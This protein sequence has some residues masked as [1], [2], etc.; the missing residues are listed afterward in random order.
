[1]LLLS[2]LVASF[3]SCGEDNPALIEEPVEDIAPI[4]SLSGDN[5]T[6]QQNITIEAG[7]VFTLDLTAKSG[8]YAMKSFSLKQSGEFVDIE[9]FTVNGQAA[10]YNP[11]LLSG[12]NK[13]SIAWNIEIRSHLEEGTKVYE[14]AIDD[15]EDLESK[16]TLMVTTEVSHTPPSFVIQEKV[17]FTAFPG[18]LVAIPIQVSTGSSLL[19]KIGVTDV[20]D[21]FIDESMLFYE[22]IDF[23]FIGN[24]MFIPVDDAE[25]LNKIIYVQAPDLGTVDYTML[26]FD[27]ND[28]AASFDFSINAGIPITSLS[29]NSLIVSGPNSH[30]GL[31]LDTGDAML[32]SDFQAELKD[33]G[34]GTVDGKPNT[35]LKKLTAVNGAGIKHV[36]PGEN[37][38]PSDFTFESVS[39]MEELITI[40]DQAQVFTTRNDDNEVESKVLEVGDVFSIKH[41]D[42]YFL[43]KIV[44]I[45]DHTADTEDYYVIDIKK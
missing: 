28:Q 5:G 37:G 19:Y 32:A 12:E 35:W 14:L 43:I 33:L 31:D 6:V 8:T 13:Q 26:V 15:D 18:S 17:D 20:N 45:H 2:F 44:E 7:E 4:L 3:I 38:L 24:P 21:E 34:Y 10:E 16:L 25:G 30:D 29:N 36:I 41:I 22:N 40:Y 27:E 23:G 9:R 11:H 1:M 42:R 39:S